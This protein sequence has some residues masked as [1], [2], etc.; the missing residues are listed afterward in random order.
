MQFDYAVYDTIYSAI[1]SQ[2]SNGWGGDTRL[3]KGPEHIAGILGSMWV[4]KS[5]QALEIGCGEGNLSRLLEMHGYR[6]SGL[7]VSASAIAWAREKAPE[8]SRIEYICGNFA[9]PDILLDRTFDL[10]LDG[11]CLHCIGSKDRGLFLRNACRLLASDGTFVVSCLC[12]KDD[13]THEVF[14]NGLGLRHIGAEND[15]LAELTQAGFE[16]L[17]A[18]R[19][20]REVDDNLL[21][22]ARKSRPL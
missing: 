4:P 10:I 3:A 18:E 13:H 12:S 6:V 16:I 14:R 8:Y 1:R 22:F 21:V 5:G 2:G 19:R 9:Q 11:A 17:Q 7:D 15:L 20:S